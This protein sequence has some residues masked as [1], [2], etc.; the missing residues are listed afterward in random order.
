[1]QQH[2]RKKIFWIF[3]KMTF[4]GVIFMRKIDC[5]HSRSL[6]ML[7]WPWFREIRVCIEAKIQ[8]VLIFLNQGQRNVFKLWEWAISIPRMKLPPEIWF[9]GKISKLFDSR[10]NI[11]LRALYPLKKWCNCVIFEWLLILKSMTIFSCRIFR[12]TLFETV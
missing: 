1:M 2:F 11:H 7:P 6:K 8:H 3:A 12:N 5:A 4:L 9:W 10:F